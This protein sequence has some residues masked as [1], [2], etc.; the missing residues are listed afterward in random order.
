MRITR[1]QVHHIAA[2]ARLRL[3]DTEEDR[4]AG[5]LDRILDYVELL[6]EVDTNDVPATAHVLDLA[7]PYRD[8]RATNEDDTDNILSNAPDR[9]GSFFRVPRIIE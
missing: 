9:S 2:L 4:L 3:S 8:D 7:T 6:N 1:E 5:E